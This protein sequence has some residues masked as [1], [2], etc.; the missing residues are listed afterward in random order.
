MGFRH[1][2]LLQHV[3]ENRLALLTAG[4]TILRAFV[5]AGRPEAGLKPWGS[6]EGWSG[7]VRNCIVW[8]GLLDPGDTRRELAEASD[9]D[10]AALRML[11]AGWHE[12]DPD[13]NGLTAAGLVKLL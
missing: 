7:L 13:E 8:L 9:R 11:F 12:V 2:N 4:L 10:A 1:P 3:R 5:V 6:F